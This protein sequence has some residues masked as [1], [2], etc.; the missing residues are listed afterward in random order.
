M[1]R[2]AAILA[3]LRARSLGAAPAAPRTP[4]ELLKTAGR[5][6]LWA[7]IGLALIRGVGSSAAPDTTPTPRVDAARVAGWPDDAARAFA[8]EFATAYLTHDPHDA[9]SQARELQT[10]ASPELAAQLAPRSEPGQPRAA[11]VSVR[12]AAVAGTARLDD[13]HALITVAAVLEGRDVSRRLVT[14]P[15]ARDTR[16]GLVVY[17]LPSFAAAPTRAT[18]GAPAG[19][20]LIGTDRAAITD[21]VAPFM[22]AYLAGD[23]SA[24]AYLV[25][26]GTHITAAAGRWEL[27]DLTSL[28]ALGPDTDTGRN[29][30]AT[31]QARDERLQLTYVLRYRL[32]LVRRDRWY[33]AAVNS[34]DEERRR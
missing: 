27:T 15:V 26:P 19:E 29:V 18:V 20:P 14:V 32:R 11:V 30:L 23:S 1:T 4:R 13:R 31:V 9:S 6:V 5:L 22:R 28:S 24:L 33:V 16:G 25:P 34:A 7:A 10:F 12:S 21:V 8:V 17:D 3:R 2:P